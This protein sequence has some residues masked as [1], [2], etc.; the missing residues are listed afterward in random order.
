M[1]AR[2]SPHVTAL[3]RGWAD[4]EGPDDGASSPDRSAGLTDRGNPHTPTAFPS[5]ENR[6]GDSARPRPSAG[7]CAGAEGDGQPLGGGGHGDG[8]P[9]CQCARAAGPTRRRPGG[10]AATRPYLSQSAGRRA[11]AGCGRGQALEKALSGMQAADFPVHPPTV[12]G[13]S[14]LSGFGKELAGSTLT[15]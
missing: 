2:A 9:V 13:A 10:S 7:R 3:H 5:A 4:A 12:Q 15:T 1:D 14:K 8:P 6:A 11:D